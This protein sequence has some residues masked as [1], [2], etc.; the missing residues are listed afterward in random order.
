MFFE[1]HQELQKQLG[2][3]QHLV[4]G[5]IPNEHKQETFMDENAH[6]SIKLFTHAKCWM[7]INP[8]LSKDE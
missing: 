8:P 5:Y 4:L 3:P 6:E 2:F 1:I 7:T